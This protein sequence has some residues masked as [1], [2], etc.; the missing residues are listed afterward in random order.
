MRF[1]RRDVLRLGGLAAVALAV[2]TDGDLPLEVEIDQDVDIRVFHTSRTTSTADLNRSL[3]WNRGK[4]VALRGVHLCTAPIRIHSGTTL[5]LSRCHLIRSH[6]GE[7]DAGGTLVNSDQA[8]GNTCIRILGARLSAPDGFSGKHIGFVRVE[9]VSIEGLIIDSCCGDFMAVFRNCAD[10]LVKEVRWSGSSYHGEDG[11]HLYGVVG[12]LVTGCIIS[13]GDDAISLTAKAKDIGRLEKIRIEKCCLESAMASAIKMHVLPS[14]PNAW[15]DDVEIVDC[16][17][18]VAVG[19]DP[20]DG[21][22]LLDATSGPSRIGSVRVAN[23]DIFLQGNRGSGIRVRGIDNLVLQ[24][25]RL[26]GFIGVGI[27]IAGQ[28]LGSSMSG[29]IELDRGRVFGSVDADRESFILR[30]LSEVLITDCSSFHSRG[31]GMLLDECDSVSISSCLVSQSI[32]PCVLVR[33]STGVVVRDSLFV[34][35]GGSV[36][37]GRDSY[38]AGNF[39]SSNTISPIQ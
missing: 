22:R 16:V 25:V 13:S 10:V 38:S 4:Y 11:L 32:G 26:S 39:E 33:E 2:S 12:C 29:P 27:W 35:C 36:Y 19:S 34:S 17:A 5:D 31:A 20:H 6:N 7:G 1:G 21:F 15:I 37:L 23:V 8:G 30:R 14:A 28:G 18:I 3:F 24:D 9:N